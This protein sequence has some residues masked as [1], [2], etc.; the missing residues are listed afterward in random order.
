MAA[1]VGLIR[2]LSHERVAFW[3]FPVLYVLAQVG[4]NLIFDHDAG[5]RA[6]KA[7]GGSGLPDLSLGLSPREW[8]TLL[9]VRASPSSVISDRIYHCSTILSNQF[10][11]EVYRRSC[12]ARRMAATAG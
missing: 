4:I 7:V 5:R 9:E 2:R 6:A 11:L 10:R 12:V 1:L 8:R 3:G